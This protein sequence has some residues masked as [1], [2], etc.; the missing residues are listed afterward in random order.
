DVL[1]GHDPLFPG[2]DANDTLLGGAGNDTIYAGIGNDSV[3]GGADTDTLNLF[4][5]R[6]DYDVTWNATT[7]TYTLLHAPTGF[8]TTAKG[9]E[10]FHFA[11]DFPSTTYD[12][13]NL[14]ADAGDGLTLKGTAAGE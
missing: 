9:V 8:T 3:D 4:G 12:W 6:A 7:R 13:G 11:G 1:F 5:S 14:V 2:A 10:F